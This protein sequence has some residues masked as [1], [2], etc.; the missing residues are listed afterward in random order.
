[1]CRWGTDTILVVPVKKGDDGQFIWAER[2]IDSC[3]ASLVQALNDSGF[4][5]SNCC[6]GHGS[7]EGDVILHDGRILTISLF[8]FVNLDRGSYYHKRLF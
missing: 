7:G 3:I 1:M 5:T 2:K 6:C 4:Y 8:K